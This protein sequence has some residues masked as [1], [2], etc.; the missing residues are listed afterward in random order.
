MLMA[1]VVEEELGVDTEDASV[2][3]VAVKMA[4]LV[5]MAGP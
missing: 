2:V 5:E 1:V 3:R 4:G